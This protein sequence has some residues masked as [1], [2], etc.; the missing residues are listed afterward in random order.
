[1]ILLL[2]VALAGSIMIAAL[3]SHCF[4]MVRDIGD[5]QGDLRQRVLQFYQVALSTKTAEDDSALMMYRGSQPLRQI[6]EDAGE[7]IRE[8]SGSPP[9]LHPTRAHGPSQALAA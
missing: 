9:L 1:M 2:A 4:F 6:L 3:I 5:A 8:E 7:E